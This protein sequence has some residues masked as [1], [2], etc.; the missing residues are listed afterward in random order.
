M[1][2]EAI[3]L[4]TGVTDPQPVPQT[5]TPVEAPKA[6]EVVKSPAA[7]LR[8]IQA[9]LANGIYPGNVAPAIVKAYQLLEKMA[10]EVE[11]SATPK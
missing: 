11:A 5:V 4:P 10:V 7:D 3:K 8:D 9:L 2:E 6:P 1:S